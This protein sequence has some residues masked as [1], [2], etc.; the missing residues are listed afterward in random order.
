VRG[1]VLFVGGTDTGVGKTVVSAAITALARRDGL[2][3][4]AMKPVETGCP[5]RPGKRRPIDGRFLRL[6]GGSVLSEGEISP[7]TLGRPA[8]P[9]VAAR[10]ERRSINLPDLK[11]SIEKLGRRHDLVV[12]EGAGGLLVPMT[13]RSL[14]IDFVISL[15]CPL[16]LVGRTALGAVNQM[17]LSL[18]A[19]RTRKIPVVGWLLNHSGGRFGLAER[20]AASEIARFADELFL[21]ILPPIRGLSVERGEFGSLADDAAR[22]VKWRTLL[23]RIEEMD[24]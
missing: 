24:G 1:R 2:D 14:Q 11:R 12:V 15:G 20:T 10:I 8:A 3:A 17:L 22:S 13:G 21:G 18:D 5:G 6:A 7:V 4:V 19:A 9:S 16:L 23:R